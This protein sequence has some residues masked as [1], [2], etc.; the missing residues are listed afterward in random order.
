M[1]YSRCLPGNDTV[2][3]L[4]CVPALTSLGVLNTQHKSADSDISRESAW[5]LSTRVLIVMFQ[6]DTQ[7]K[8]TDRN[9]PEGVVIHQV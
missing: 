2:D 1:G 6:L 5:I 7:Y 9:V 4:V 8:S 3:N